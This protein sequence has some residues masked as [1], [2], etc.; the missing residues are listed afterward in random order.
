VLRAVK[1]KE[2]GP[3]NE[4]DIS[5]YTTVILF[6]CHKNITVKPKVNKTIDFDY[7]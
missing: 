5:K 2:L 4:Y 3:T 7:Y 1:A 6:H